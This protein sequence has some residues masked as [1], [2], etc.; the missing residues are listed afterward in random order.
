[1]RPFELISVA[2]GVRYRREDL[3]LLCRAIESVLQQTHSNL[4]FL[5]CENDSTQ[6]AKALLAQ[7]ALQD[8][9][10][11]LIDGSGTSL[12]SEKLNRCIL[13][14]KGRWIARQDDDDCSLPDRLARQ[15]EFLHV[16]RQYAFVGCNVKIEQGDEVVGIRNFPMAPKIK[17]F[18]FVQPFI[19]PALL[20]RRDCLEAV[21]CYS[22]SRFCSGCEDYDL[23]L[24]LYQA[25]YTGAN[26]SEPCFIYHT[27]PPGARTRSYSMRVNELVTRWNR[28]YALGLLPGALPYVIKPV[29]VG[30]IPQKLLYRI[31]NM[32]CI[33]TARK[34]P[35][36]E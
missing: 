21:E 14:A 2:M 17:D 9:R 31:K 30:L 15:V 33:F 24:R 11:R 7:Y 8:S 13:A 34:G 28:F 6:E 12:L 36:D 29:V 19:H 1:M 26:L 16:N 35:T 23:L 22:E 20:F 27:P 3:T 25:G 4:E 18:L 10:I 32:H 5:I